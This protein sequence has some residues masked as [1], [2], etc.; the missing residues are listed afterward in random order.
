MRKIILGSVVIIFLFFSPM[1]FDAAFG[2]EEASEQTLSLLEPVGQSAAFQEYLNKPKS[3]LAKLL[4]G[5]N[6]FR[7]APVMVQYDGV[8]YAPQFAY[9]LGLAYLLTRYHGEKPES[10]IRKHCYRSPT[11]NKIIYFKFSDGN[12]RPVRDV[13]IETYEALEKAEQKVRMEGAEQ[14][15]TSW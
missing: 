3:N 6:Y 12:F 5:L 9:P 1:V 13:F 2:S 7:N 15:G 10:W 4:F 8:E 14:A 11:A